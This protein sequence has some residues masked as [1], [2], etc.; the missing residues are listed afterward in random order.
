MFYNIF[1][2]IY[3]D[4]S[5]SVECKSHAV[6]LFRKSYQPSINNLSITYQSPINHLSIMKECSHCQ[7][8]NVK[9][10]LHKANT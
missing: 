6:E 7:L 5:V 3:A 9:L 8:C 2:M 10:P 1:L 4:D